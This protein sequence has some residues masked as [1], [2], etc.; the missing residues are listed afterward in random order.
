VYEWEDWINDIYQVT[1]REIIDIERLPFGLNE[2]STVTLLMNVQD[3]R[4]KRPT[5]LNT[6]FNYG[7]VEIQVAG[8]GEPL[9]FHSVSRPQ[10]IVE[11]IFRRSEAFRIKRMERETSIL[12]RQMVDALVAYHRLLA[13]E[14]H[15]TTSDETMSQ[16]AAPVVIVQPTSVIGATA[17]VPQLGSPAVAAPPPEVVTPTAV[18]PQIVPR[19]AEDKLSEFPPAEVYEESI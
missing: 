11:E 3:V 15:G 17:P 4:S 1:E 5:L 14:K 18:E 6:F 19:Q 2:R 7:N 9:I 13:E 12:S 16:V 10:H 8:G